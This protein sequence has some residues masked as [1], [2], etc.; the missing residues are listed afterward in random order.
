MSD[1]GNVGRPYGAILALTRNANSRP[2]FFLELPEDV[3]EA[4]SA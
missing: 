2:E 1:N 4:K 3:F